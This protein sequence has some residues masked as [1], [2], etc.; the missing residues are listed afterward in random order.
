VG[1]QRELRSGIYPKRFSS[2]VLSAPLS[3]HVGTGWGVPSG[4]LAPKGRLAPA[5]YRNGRPESPRMA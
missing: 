1:P 4:D 3:T 2:W 5:I